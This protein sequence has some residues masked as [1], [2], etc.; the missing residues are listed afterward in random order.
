MMTI[1]RYWR[2]SSASR[3]PRVILCVEEIADN[4]VR[5]HLGTSGLAGNTGSLV[6]KMAV[7]KQRGV[8]NANGNKIISVNRPWRID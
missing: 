2:L 4:V 8:R 6:K 1:R 7:R 3:W 5:L